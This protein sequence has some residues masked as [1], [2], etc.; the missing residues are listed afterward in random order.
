MVSLVTLP[1]I[2]EIGGCGAILDG[3]QKAHPIRRLARQNH[4]AG[5][6]IVAYETSL[7]SKR[8]AISNRTAWLRPV[9]NIFA[10][11]VTVPPVG[12]ISNR[13]NYSQEARRSGTIRA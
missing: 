5:Q 9:I 1:G 13:R 12:Y 6:R 4:A 2:E 3:A 7:T 11:P 8:Y 10:M